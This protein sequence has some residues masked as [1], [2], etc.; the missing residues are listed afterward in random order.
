MAY[1]ARIGG[2]HMTENIYMYFTLLC[3]FSS[4]IVE[5]LK[6]SNVYVFYVVVCVK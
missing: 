1:G 5:S 6:V 4:P 3:A 2:E